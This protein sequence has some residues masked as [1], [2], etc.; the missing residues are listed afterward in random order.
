MYTAASSPQL[1]ASYLR[2]ARPSRNLARAGRFWVSGRGLQV[3]ERGRHSAIVRYPGPASHATRTWSRKRP[4]TR[5]AHQRRIRCTSSSGD[6]TQPP[7]HH[8]SSTCGL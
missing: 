7:A 6:L 5:W 8:S 3:L 1:A 4:G 2:T